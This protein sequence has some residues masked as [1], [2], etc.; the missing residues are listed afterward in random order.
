VSKVVGQAG[1]VDGA[2]LRIAIGVVAARPS[3]TAAREDVPCLL[4]FPRCRDTTEPR[5]ITESHGTG[6]QDRSSAFR[7]LPCPAWS[8]SRP[9]AG[10]KKGLKWREQSQSISSVKALPG[11]RLS[12]NSGRG[13]RA[14]KAN[15]AKG[16]DHEWGESPISSRRNDP[17][18]GVLPGLFTGGGRDPPVT[19]KMRGAEGDFES[20]QIKA[21]LKMGKMVT[22]LRGS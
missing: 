11:M 17:A 15:S 1:A 6:T 7:V 19:C 18:S 13:G 4:S 3:A 22:T 16:Q 21:N 2:S 12:Q 9:P 10:V 20:V 8:G 5:N 14:N